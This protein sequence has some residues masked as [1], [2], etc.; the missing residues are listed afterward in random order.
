ME[1]IAAA[2]EE[3]Q[4]LENQLAQPEVYSD[5]QKSRQVESQLAAMEAKI[6]ELT[7]AWEAVSAQLEGCE[8]LQCLTPVGALHQSVLCT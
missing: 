1:E 8:K 2:E 3:K 6:E 4:E 5:L 7:A